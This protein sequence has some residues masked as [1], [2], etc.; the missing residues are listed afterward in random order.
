MANKLNN[1]LKFTEYDH[2]QPKQKPTGKTEIGGFAVLE[3]MSVKDLLKLAALET[4]MDKKELQKLSPKKLKKLAGIKKG[5]KPEIKPKAEPEEK[6]EKKEEKDEKKN[7]GLLFEKKAS[8]KQIAARKKFME[9]ISSKKKGGADK[10]EGKD[11][12]PAKKEFPFKKKAKK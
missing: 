9:M 3:G 5:D 7:E 2:L 4:G 11:E 10:E 6:E 12:K 1:M 8:A